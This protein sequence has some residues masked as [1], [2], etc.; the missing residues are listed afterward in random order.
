MRGPSIQNAVRTVCVV[1]NV[2]I[3][4][5]MF[6]MSAMDDDKPVRKLALE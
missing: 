6:E 4:L 1:L 2:V 3:G 5:Y